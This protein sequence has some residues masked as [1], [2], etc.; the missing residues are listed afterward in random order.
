ML[1]EDF[2]KN[3]GREIDDLLRQHDEKQ[4]DTSYVNGPWK[5]MY[6]SDRRSLMLNYNPSIQ[7]N[8][9]DLPYL[10]QLRTATAIIVSLARFHL[11]MRDQLLEPE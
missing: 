6:L 1:W 10:D 4:K 2:A 11:T 3:E 8:T 7:L 5:E 9:L